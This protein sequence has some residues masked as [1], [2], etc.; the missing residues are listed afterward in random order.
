MEPERRS[1]V[2]SERA[3]LRE[4]TLAT[5][6]EVD[7]CKAV[8]RSLADFGAFVELTEFQGKREGLVHA[9]LMSAKKG[10]SAR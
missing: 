7:V 4:R 8:V 5:L 2:L 10:V 9:S 3:E 1:L 6:K